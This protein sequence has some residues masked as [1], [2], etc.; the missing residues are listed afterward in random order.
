MKIFLRDPVYG[1][2][3][4]NPDT[5]QESNFSIKFSIPLKYEKGYKVVE[6][7]W[8]NVAYVEREIHIEGGKESSD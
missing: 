2:Y 5:W 1:K 3:M 7:P 8:S 6:V 4:W